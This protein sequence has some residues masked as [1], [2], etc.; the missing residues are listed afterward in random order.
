MTSP[1]M[2][3]AKDDV[4]IGKRICDGC[5]GGSPSP[6]PFPLATPFTEDYIPATET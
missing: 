3:P 2:V 5:N 4:K 6:P 1:N